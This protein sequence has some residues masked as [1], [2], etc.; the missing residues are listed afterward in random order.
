MLISPASPCR[1]VEAHGRQSERNTIGKGETVIIPPPAPKR[2]NLLL[3]EG[4]QQLQA[5][6]QDGHQ[7][8]AIVAT[9]AQMRRV[10]GIARQLAST[11]ATALIQGESGTGKE[12]IA[13]AIHAWSPRAH[14]PLIT[15]DCTTIPES[16][17]ESELFGHERGAFTGALV[18]KRGLFEEGNCGTI[19]LDEVGEMPLSAQ[20]KLLRVLQEQ[21]IRRVGGTTSIHIDV[22]VLAATNKDLRTLVQK[23]RFREDLYYRLNGVVI[24]LPPLR[25]RPEDILALAHHFLDMYRQQFGRKVAG[26]A[27]ET[28]EVLLRYAWPGNV[29]EMEKAIER[30][31]ILGRTHLIMPEDLP[32]SLLGGEDFKT[33]VDHKRSTLMQ[34]EKAH[35]LAALSDHRWNQTKVAAEL[36][37]SRTT[38]WRKMKRYDIDIPS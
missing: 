29:R 32:P 24:T 4:A 5:P 9:S 2:D 15:I 23:R 37:I 1:S 35:I 27:P 13:K 20:A 16:L 21:I 28:I 17:M 11:H 34:L 10:L 26:I 12:V 22:R 3:L 6:L 30:A 25:E 7:S 8:D 33:A 31:V 19:F 18:T 14:Q 36:G 38:L